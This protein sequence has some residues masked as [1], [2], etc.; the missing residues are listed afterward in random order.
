M[1]LKWLPVLERATCNGTKILLKDIY[2]RAFLAGLTYRESC[3]S[4]R[5]ARRDRVGDITIGD[6]WGLSKDIA[7][8]SGA[9]DGVS[10]VLVNT[11]KGEKLFYLCKE[12]LVF[13]ERTLEEARRENMQ[14]NFPTKRPK[15]RI[16]FLFFYRAF[17]FDMACNAAYFFIYLQLRFFNRIRN[18]YNRLVRQ[19]GRLSNNR[20]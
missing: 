17:G 10:V 19:P 20:R 5:Y 2:L 16:L 1:I 3:Y 13:Y 9:K 4:C 15:S 18:L 12:K 14:L 6:F 8:L 7:S 11:D